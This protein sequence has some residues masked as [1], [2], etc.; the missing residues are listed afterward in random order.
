MPRAVRPEYER[1][2]VVDVTPSRDWFET[3]VLT[4][5]TKEQF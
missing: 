4:E 3:L 2:E 5:P 1:M